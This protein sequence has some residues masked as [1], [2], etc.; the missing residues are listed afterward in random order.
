MS[1]VGNLEDL[2]L[3]DILQII[4]LSQ[5]SGVLAL[6]GDEGSGRIFFRAGLVQAAAVK[7]RPGD[8]R[9]LLVGASL[10]E[11]PAFDAADARARQLG[12]PIRTTNRV[13]GRT[14]AVQVGDW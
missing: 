10:I 2:S 5:K 12:Q 14:G 8:L 3:G 11:V 4:S 6:E 9:A 7:G 13:S 1:L